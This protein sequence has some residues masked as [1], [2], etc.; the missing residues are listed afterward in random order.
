[1]A[2]AKEIRSKIAG[3]KNTK[4]I[5]GAMEKV[6]ASKMKKAQERQALTLPYANTLRR[7]V[8]HIAHAHAEYR[9][10]YLDQRKI[11]KVGFI[12]VTTDRGLCGPLNS[13]LFKMSLSMLRDFS[14]RQIEAELCLI[15]SKGLNFYKRTGAKIV[16]HAEHLG[17][18]PNSSDLIGIVK[19]MIDKY[20]NKEIDKLYLL[21]N[22]FVNTMVQKPKKIQLLPVLPNKNEELKYHWDYIYEPDSRILLDEI[23]KRYMENLVYQGVVENIACEQASRMV[24]MKNA[25]ENASDLISDLQLVY[26]KAR[27]A[28]ITK[29]IAEIVGG[30]SAV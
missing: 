1:M 17:D 8:R 24:A 2:S 23:M 10:Q 21:H 6:A 29:E 25:S 16:A 5:T 13:N 19:V 28:A 4:K 15:G 18:T 3:I 26:N 11:Q 20:V 14:N 22:K 27:Q 9:H 7:L 12:I 30:A